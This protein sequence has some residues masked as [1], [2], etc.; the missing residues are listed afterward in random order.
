[1]YINYFGGMRGGGPKCVVSEGS[2]ILL[3][4]H[5]ETGTVCGG[6]YLR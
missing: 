4:K 5:I 2:K 1:M 3:Q 6:G